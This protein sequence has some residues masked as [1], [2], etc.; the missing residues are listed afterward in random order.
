V[1]LLLGRL[2]WNRYLDELLYPRYVVI[3]VVISKAEKRVP[4]GLL[5][6]TTE[7]ITL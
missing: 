1:C 7:C 4:Y 2:Y 6:G 5:V 3:Y